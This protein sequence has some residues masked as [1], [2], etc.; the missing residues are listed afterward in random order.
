MRLLL[1]TPLGVPVEPEVN[2]IL[3]M[4]AGARLPYAAWTSGLGL[5]PARSAIRAFAPSNRVRQA[6]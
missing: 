6:A 1:S 5:L 4:A 2:E 3:A